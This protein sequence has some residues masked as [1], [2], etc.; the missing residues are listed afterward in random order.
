MSVSSCR[1]NPM[2]RSE[3]ALPSRMAKCMSPVAATAEIMVTLDRLPV[4][5]TIG[6]RPTGAQ[7]V[8][9]WKSVRTLA[10]SAK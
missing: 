1:Q 4:R 2:N 6:V 8:P 9:E 7:V 3:V 5:R 10:S